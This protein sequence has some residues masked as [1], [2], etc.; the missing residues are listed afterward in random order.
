[1]VHHLIQF[2]AVLIAFVVIDSVWL[3]LVMRRFYSDQLGSLMRDQVQWPAAIAFYVLFAVC[4]TV[5]ALAPADR[6]GSWTTAAFLGAVVGLA[7]YGTYNLTNLATI[8][9]FPATLALT[10]LAWGTVLSAVAATVG[11]L[12]ARA[13]Q[14]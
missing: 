12:A 10:D 5:L 7:G 3:G 13:M 1:M 4:L 6:S 8:R 14:G 2:G 9:G 11:W